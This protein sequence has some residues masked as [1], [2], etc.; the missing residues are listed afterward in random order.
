MVLHD[1]PERSEKAI[2]FL[3][4]GIFQFP[5]IKHAKKIYPTLLVVPEVKGRVEKRLT[6]IDKAVAWY[7]IK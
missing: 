5:D 7:I 2:D 3:A 1:C 6:S 4:N